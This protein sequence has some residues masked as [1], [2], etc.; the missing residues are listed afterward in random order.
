MRLVS[1]EMGVVTKVDN[2]KLLAPTIITLFDPIGK[3]YNPPI[4]YDLSLKQKE[5]NGIDFVVE[6]SLDPL[7]YGVNV[8]E[9][10]APKPVVEQ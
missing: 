4:E 1:G 10:I 5:R 7:A 3:P 9:F 2:G 8:D 6:I